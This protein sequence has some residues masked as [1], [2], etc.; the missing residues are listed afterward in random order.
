MTLGLRFL[1][2]V[3]LATCV[4]GIAVFAA[5]PKKRGFVL[6]PPKAGVYAPWHNS[7]EALGFYAGEIITLSKEAFRY[8]LKTDVIEED[9]ILQ[10][11]E[12]SLRIFEGH[13]YLDH[14]GVPFPYRITGYLD[15]VFVMTTWRTFERWKKFGVMEDYEVLYLQAATKRN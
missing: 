11:W 5:A 14:P 12:G 2:S 7:T 10:D 6:A 4:S 8:Q 13:I 1:F 3:L 9:N 15:G